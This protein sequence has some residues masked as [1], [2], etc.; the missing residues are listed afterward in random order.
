MSTLLELKRGFR[1]ARPDLRDCGGSIEGIGRVAAFLAPGFSGFSGLGSSASAFSASAFLAA[2]SAAF[3]TAF[4]AGAAAFSGGSQ[5]DRHSRRRPFQRPPS[6]RPASSPRLRRACCAALARHQ[7]D[8]RLRLFAGLL[9]LGCVSA[10]AAAGR[11]LAPLPRASRRPAQQAWRTDCRASGLGRRH[12][13]AAASGRRRTDLRFQGAPLLAVE[14]FVALLAEFLC[15]LERRHAGGLAILLQVEPRRALHPLQ[16][17]GH[18]IGLVQV[19]GLQGGPLLE[20]AGGVFR[21]PQVQIGQ[22]TEVIAPRV[23]RT[24]GNGPGEQ[25]V[26]LT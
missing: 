8:S 16:R 25:A 24:G 11:P 9:R 10:P 22:A 19:G 26:G 23:V 3:L 18:V 17:L 1:Q 6:W 4:F 12:R 20:I 13:L 14:F 2:F 5:T 15:L 7:R 21:T